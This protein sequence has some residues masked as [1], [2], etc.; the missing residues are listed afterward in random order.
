MRPKTK[1][2]KELALKIASEVLSKRKE[3][4][5]NQK[6]VA[7]YLGFTAHTAITNIENGNQQITA[8]QYFK[9]MNLQKS[10]LV[11]VKFSIKRGL[12]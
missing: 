3:L 2:D 12:K 1:E 7:D 10:D 5:V 6:S 4:G 11:P 8:W 9:L